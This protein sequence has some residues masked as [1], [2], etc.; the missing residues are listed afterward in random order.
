MLADDRYRDADITER[1]SLKPGELNTTADP[2]ATP[3]ASSGSPNG[4][5]APSIIFCRRSSRINARA[6]ASVCR[7]LGQSGRKRHKHRS[8][9]VCRIFVSLKIVVGLFSTMSL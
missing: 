6:H 9:T 1:L 2:V 3:V 7:W 8:V 4:A 5:T